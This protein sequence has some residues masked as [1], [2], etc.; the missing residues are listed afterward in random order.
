MKKLTTIKSMILGILLLALAFPA[1]AQKSEAAIVPG[2]DPRPDYEPD[3]IQQDDVRIEVAM[4]HGS[5]GSGCYTHV[6]AAPVAAPKIPVTISMKC[7]S[8]K[9]TSLEY[10]MQDQD[11][12]PV[13]GPD[14]NEFVQDLEL[15]PFSASEL[16]VA[17]RGAF[18]GNAS[19]PLLG[20]HGTVDKDL[21]E[22]IEVSGKC[23]DDSDTEPKPF[24]VKVSVSCKDPSLILGS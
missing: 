12:V 15:Q 24:P 11:P 3:L 10:K 13:P 20:S 4:K 18:G 8:K 2:G 22:D 23:G 5:C 21:V 14:G 1:S 9:V 16:E 6:L 17:C 7:G 19:S